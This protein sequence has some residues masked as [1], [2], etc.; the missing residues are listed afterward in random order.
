MMMKLTPQVGNFHIRQRDEKACL[1]QFLKTQFF[2]MFKLL[3]EASKYRERERERET[4][5]EREEEES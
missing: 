1:S 4:E 5:T 3:S 2:Q